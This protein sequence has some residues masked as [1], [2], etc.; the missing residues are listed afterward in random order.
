MLGGSRIPNQEV[1]LLPAGA[2]AQD[3]EAVNAS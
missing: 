1:P 3:V 2:A